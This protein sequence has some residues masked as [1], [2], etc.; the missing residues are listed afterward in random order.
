MITFLNLGSQGRLGNQLFQYAALKG[1]GLKNNYE[2]KIPNPNHKN[3]HGQPCLLSEFNIE[4]GYLEETDLTSLQYSYEEPSPYDIDNNFYNIPDK[5]SID[6]FFQSIYYFEDFKDQIKKELTPKQ[7][8]LNKN[9]EYINQIK[10]SYPG[11]E[12]VSVHIRRGDNMTNNQQEL[13]DAYNENGLYFTYF[14]KAKEVFK[15]KP[16]KFLIFTGGARGNEDNASDFEWCKTHF[17][18]DEYVFSEGQKQMDDFCR[19]MLCDHNIMSH[20]SSFGW[21][22]AYLNPNKN[23]TVVAPKYY[24]PSAPDLIKYKYYPEDYIL[25]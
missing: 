8:Y 5:T 23:K 15:N 7:E 13:I 9:Q 10:A 3:W 18:G 24:H 19:I 16:V 11:Y 14:N 12:L 21:W 1:L 20:V 17:V 6:G 4:S 2:V 22:A 25:L